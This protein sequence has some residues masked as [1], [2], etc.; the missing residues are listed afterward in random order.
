MPV[1][2]NSS[3]DRCR[4]LEQELSRQQKIINVLM[5]RVERNMDAQGGAFSLFQ[6]AS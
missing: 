3:E 6:A 4:I 1:D 5:D 2:R